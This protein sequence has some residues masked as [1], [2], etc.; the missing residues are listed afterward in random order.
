MKLPLVTVVRQEHPAVSRT[1]DL[2]P[3]RTS[4]RLFN[5]H[6]VSGRECA[7]GNRRAACRRCLVWSELKGKTMITIQVKSEQDLHGGG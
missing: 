7:N 6:R 2:Q 4:R 1:N 3:N 5:R